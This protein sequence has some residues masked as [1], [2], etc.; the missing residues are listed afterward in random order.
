MALLYGL[1]RV[2]AF[3]LMKKATWK[4]RRAK[5]RLEKA[6]KAFREIENACKAEEVASGRPANFASQFKMM[7]QFELRDAANGRWK[8]AAQ[9][10]K[11]RE[12][13]SNWL[14]TATGKKVPYAFGLVD[15][16]LALGIYQWVIAEPTRV[17]LISE[18]AAK[19]W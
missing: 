18:L 13:V 7:K 5:S 6:D 15:M 17:Q 11:K 14:K 9:K 3:A 10:M 19:V 4:H 16:T 12:K 8:L 2:F 1:L